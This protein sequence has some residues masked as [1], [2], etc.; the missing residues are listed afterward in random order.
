MM[1]TKPRVSLLGQFVQEEHVIMFYL[2][3]EIIYIVM[4]YYNSSNMQK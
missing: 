3:Y 1:P 2:D 4:V